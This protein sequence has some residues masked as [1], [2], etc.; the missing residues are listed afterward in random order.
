M[1]IWSF[2]KCARLYELQIHFFSQFIVILKHIDMINHIMIILLMQMHKLMQNDDNIC[3]IKYNFS[4]FF[5]KLYLT[6]Q[7][8]QYKLQ[9]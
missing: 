2:H 9:N 8:I 3:I 7:I 6:Y 1:V 4:L 5:I